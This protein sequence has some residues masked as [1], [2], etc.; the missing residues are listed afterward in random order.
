[1]AKYLKK[2]SNESE[3][4][5][6][7]NGDNV[8][9]PNVSL[10]GTDDVRY[11]PYDYSKDY[12]TFEILSSGYVSFVCSFPFD[13]IYTKTIQYSKNGNEWTNLT[14]GLNRNIPTAITVD[15]KS[16]IYTFGGFDED[17]GM[18]YWEN[19]DDKLYYDDMWDAHVG[20]TV[21]DSEWNEYEV[22]TIQ[23]EFVGTKINVVSGDIIQFRGDNS[24]YCVEDDY[25]GWNSLYSSCNFN[26][27]GNIMSLINSTGFTTATTLTDSA[28]FDGFFQSCSG[29]TS[30]KNLILP[31]TTLANSCYSSMF[32][33]CTSLTT[34]P[35][36]LPATTLANNCYSDMF[37]A[38]TSLTTAPSILPATTLANNCYS[39][40]FKGCTSLTTAPELPATTLAT[41]CYTYMFEDCTSLTTAPELPA[42]TLANSCYNMMFLDCTSLTT[43]PEL[44]ATTLT[45]GCYSSMFKGCTSLTTAPE[46]P[47]ITLANSCY[48]SMFEDC[49]SLTTAPELPATTLA[50]SCYG[51][52]FNGCTSLTTAPELSATTLANSCYSHMFYGCTSLTTAPELPATTL[53]T[54][55][56]RYMFYGCTSLNYIKCLATNI[57]ANNCTYNW[58]SGVASNGTFIKNP[59]MSSWGRGT[60]GIPSGWTVQDAS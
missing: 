26:V 13:N 42:T 48:G 44:P 1:M 29:L 56:Y 17:M 59:N 49:T 51:N 22:L 47:A 38:C 23:E 4:N 5:T 19:G 3:Y 14:S 34:A 18:C 53:A 31:A 7:I 20:D 36:I 46:L 27:C 40:M 24:S 60:S 50:I 55:C 52:M 58:V 25:D 12:L 16:G 21:Y 9:L 10:I 32:K 33:G 2:F 43:A 37:R 54:F 41:F 11:K 45:E 30:A 15:G 39:S 6:Y 35:S 28:N 57:S 8:Y